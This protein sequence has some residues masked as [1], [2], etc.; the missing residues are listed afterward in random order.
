[1]HWYLEFWRKYGD[2]SGRARRKEYWLSYLINMII[3][4]VLAGVEGVLWQ[5]PILTLVYALAMLVP[6]VAV[7]VRRLH[8][9]DRS[10]WW[11]LIPLVPAVGGII[12]FIFT[13]LD[14]TPG[15]NMYGPNPKGLSISY[16]NPSSSTPAE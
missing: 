16:N 2:F 5:L 13:V 10:G 11:F 6:A 3:I 15:D 14:S 12:L 8:D 7:T 4:S 9:I 1:M